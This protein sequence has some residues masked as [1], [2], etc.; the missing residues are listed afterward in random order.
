MKGYR[1]FITFILVAFIVGIP[2]TTMA[3]YIPEPGF[4]TDG[5]VADDIGGDDRAYSMVVQPDGKILVAGT[6]DLNTN[7]KQVVVA[8]YNSDGSTDTTFN[9]TGVASFQIATL[10]SVANSI[11]LLADNSI[12]VAGYAQESSDEK[13][14][15][16]M[17]LT[18]TGIQDLDFGSSGVTTL[19]IAG[20]KGEAFDITIDTSNRIVV[21]GT[22]ESDTDSW[23]FSARFS[24]NG[25]I[26]DTF[27]TNGYVQLED[28]DKTSATS[29]SLQ[30]DGKIL[31]AGMKEGSS[32][33]KKA[34]IFRLN[35]DGTADESFADNGQAALTNLS[36]D[37]RFY[38]ATALSDDAIVAVGYTTANGRR[39]MTTAKFKSTGP[40]DTSFGMSGVV[41]SDL[42]NDSA[43]YSISVKSD[44][45]LLITGEAENGSNSDI[46]LLHLDAQGQKL[47]ETA[48]TSVSSDSAQEEAE[49]SLMVEE[50]MLVATM[51]EG[52]AVYADIGGQEDYGRDLVALDDEHVIIAGFTDNSKDDDIALLKFIE[53]SRI[54]TGGG[55]STDLAYFVG[56]IPVYNVTRNSAMTGGVISVNSSYECVPTSTTTTCTAPTVTARGV[57]Y[58]IAAYPS[59][60]VASTDDG[61]SG[62]SDD[63]DSGNSVFPDWTNDSSYNYDTVRSGQTEDGSDYGTYGSD[64]NEITP[65]VFYFVR[66]YAVLSDDTVLY[67]NQLTFRTEDACFIATAAYGSPL[68]AHVSVLREFRDNYLKTT[69]AGQSF[70]GFYYHWSPALADFISQSS[71]LR[72]AA[73]LALLPFVVFSYFMVHLSLQLKLALIM[74]MGCSFLF[75]QRIL[76]R[77]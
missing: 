36:A 17:K 25:V 27:G 20:I 50:P 44:S 8:R 68:D 22:L 31:L 42:G 55:A 1:K 47:G 66:A 72:F 58:G 38:S 35:Q 69:K 19:P 6:S 10:E 48:I 32:S 5:I 67:G 60:R 73:R 11:F 71:L 24:A 40:S 34:T 49:E 3:G 12:L 37:S 26:D 33:L 39:S 29:I 7:S 65:D 16:L 4:G 54:G 21:G 77:R 61:S 62:G 15:L 14:I 2:V 43:A 9:K 53:D 45:T 13:N 59:Y 46:I 30:S 75:T 76:A 52:R 64:I 56:T 74:L 51:R 63:G 28:D 18:E 23:A 41:I 57:A 70:V